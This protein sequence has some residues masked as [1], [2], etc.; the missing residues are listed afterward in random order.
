M[1]IEVET[2]FNIGDVV[3]V[4]ESHLSWLGTGEPSKV[5]GVRVEYRLDS[6]GVINP[7]IL[8]ELSNELFHYNETICFSTFEESQQWCR[9][10]NEEGGWI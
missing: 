4:P 7:V 6:S 1:K 9:E 3:Y 10:Q 5:T 2:K 8:Y